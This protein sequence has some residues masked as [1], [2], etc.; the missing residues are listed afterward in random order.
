[1]EETV[2]PVLE[3]LSEQAEEKTPPTPKESLCNSHLLSPAL[4][5]GAYHQETKTVT[6]K[7]FT[8]SQFQED[9][10]KQLPPEGFAEDSEERSEEEW[11]ES[12][13]SAYC[14]ENSSRK[15]KKGGSK[16]K[17]TKKYVKNPY[18]R[19]KK[20]KIQATSPYP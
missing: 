2:A 13:M 15:Q 8:F 1:M 5:G 7:H 10:T 17:L 6:P 20:R 11:E 9:N 4:M 14:K 12:I 19:S 16:R 18:K 3:Y